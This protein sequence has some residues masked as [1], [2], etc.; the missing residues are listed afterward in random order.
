MGLGDCDLPLSIQNV[1]VSPIPGNFDFRILL[2]KKNSFIDYNTIPLEM[3][4]FTMN[5]PVPKFNFANIYSSSTAIS[6]PFNLIRSSF[7]SSLEI[8]AE[9][10]INF[11]FTIIDEK[12]VQHWPSDLG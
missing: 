8:P 11:N 6:D 4:Q 9:G 10:A 7:R 12:G 1:V 2:F 3:D 5:I